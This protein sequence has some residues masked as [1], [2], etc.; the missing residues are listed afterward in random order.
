VDNRSLSIGPSL[1]ANSLQ[2]AYIAALFVSFGTKNLYDRGKFVLDINGN[3]NC[4]QANKSFS[5]KLYKLHNLYILTPKHLRTF[6]GPFLKF[7]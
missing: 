4:P 7:G 5:P 3:P 2:N 1:K 6:F